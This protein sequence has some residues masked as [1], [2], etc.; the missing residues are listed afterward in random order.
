MSKDI[1]AVAI[2][3]YTK[4]W[5]ND[6]KGVLELP[7]ADLE[8]AIQQARTDLINQAAEEGILLSVAADTGDFFTITK[9]TW[10]VPTNWIGV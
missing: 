4:H 8:D 10:G 1:S 3:S 6:T 2:V 9:A 5:D 7:V